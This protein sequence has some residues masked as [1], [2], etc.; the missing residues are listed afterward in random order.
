MAEDRPQRITLEDYSS[1][2]TP[3]YFT[4]IARPKVQAVNITY[5]HSLIQLIQG[6]LFYGLPNEDPYAYLPTYIEIS[7]RWRYLE[8]TKMSSA[9]TCSSSPWL[10]KQKDGCTRSREIAY[11]HWKRWWRSFWRNI[12]QSPRPLRGRWRF[13]HSINSPMNH[14]EKLLTASMVYSERLLPKGSPEY[15]HWW[16]VTSFESY[17]MPPLV[18]R[19]NW[20]HLMKLWSLLKTWQPVTMPSFVIELTCLQRRVFLSS[21]HKT[22]Y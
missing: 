21:H 17:L 9:S 22:H 15:I 1:T 4:S 18:E 10:V 7:T 5:P 2:S 3:Q 6:N 11:K 12:F 19:S 14:W 13:L 16:L 8:F 20:R